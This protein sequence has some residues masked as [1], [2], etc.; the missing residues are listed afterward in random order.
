L[1]D[2]AE[3]IPIGL[4]RVLN[5]VSY[6]DTVH[7]A[8]RCVKPTLMSLGE[9]DPAVRP[10][11]AEAVFDALTGEKQLVRYAGGH[12]WDEGMIENNLAWFRQWL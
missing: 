6:F 1:N 12:D 5:T 10:E 9:K 8:S 11:Y 2:Y 3:S 7:Q 4:Q